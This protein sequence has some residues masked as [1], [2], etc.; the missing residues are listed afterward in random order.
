MWYVFNARRMMIGSF[1]TQSSAHRSAIENGGYY[2]S[3]NGLT[4]AELAQVD[5]HE[6]EY[7]QWLL[8]NG[9]LPAGYTQQVV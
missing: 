6:R 3:R 4:T 8:R 9:Y 5:E 2:G 1:M 7:D